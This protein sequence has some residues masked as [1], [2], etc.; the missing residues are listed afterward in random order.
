MIKTLPDTATRL[1]KLLASAGSHRLHPAMV[2]VGVHRLPAP[3]VLDLQWPDLDLA[4]GR[5]RLPS[6]WQQVGTGT[7]TL[8]HW[9]GCRQRLDRL[10]V[11][12]SWPSGLSV[13]VDEDGH[14]YAEQRG[15]EVVAEMA[16][17][18]RLP[19]LTLAALRHPCLTG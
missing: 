9:H 2:L 1:Q 8:L 5:V 13:F 15:D 17:S 16:R 3:D 12:V 19:P 7:A 10:T 11:G 6:G 18:A 4:Q 14:A